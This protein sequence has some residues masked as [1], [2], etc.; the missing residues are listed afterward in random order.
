MPFAAPILFLA[1][2]GPASAQEVGWPDLSSPVED[3]AR[4]T[5]KD[6]ALVVGISEYAQLPDI[7]GASSLAGAWHA[8]FTQ[9]RE[10][11]TRRAILLRDGEATRAAV[12][13]AAAD[14]ALEVEGGGTLWIVFI[15]HGATLPSGTDALLL[16]SDTG[17]TPE[18]VVAGGVALGSLL[19]LATIATSSSARTVMLLDASFTGRD[20][21]GARL[22]EG[23]PEARPWIGR[24]V[25]DDV[26]LFLGAGD[27]GTARLL[28]GGEWPAFGYLSLGALRGWA[29]LDRDGEVSA[30]EVRTWT[31]T[32]L[33][34]L[35]LSADQVP[36]LR[37]RDLG[38]VL[39]RRA[40][41]GPDLAAPALEATGRAQEALRTA[42]LE[43]EARLRAEV[44]EAWAAVQALPDAER[45]GAARAFLSRYA[46]ARVTRGGLTRWV[47]LPQRKEAR[48]LLLAAEPPGRPAPLTVEQASYQ[49]LQEE[50][51]HLATRNAWKGVDAA[52]LRMEALQ[53]AG[54]VLTG[55]DLLAAA[56]ASRALG[57]VR[58]L[59]DR[60][61]RSLTI[62]PS[63]E[64]VEW[65]N[66]VE[67][68]YGAVSLRREIPDAAPVQ[69]VDPPF[70][71]EERNA[72]DFGNQALEAEAA[73]DGWLPTGLYRFG[74]E[75]LL[76][77][78]G[79]ACDCRLGPSGCEVRR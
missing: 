25:G 60:L 45:A 18:G 29:D 44:E 12:A 20:R 4:G 72:I 36:D 8:W 1:L 34:S 41:A 21:D 40:E 49:Q 77:T 76:V 17:A 10:I 58:T 69:P 28:P 24:V 42:L 79:S 74:G 27:T 38:R 62:Q 53:G 15:G 50:M 35:N 23:L 78:P 5:R 55:A 67:A 59:R 75:V 37:G 22:V 71:P 11:P 39:G 57:D 32:T 54:A 13:H 19:D 14:L 65:L 26:L 70:S 9:A 63:P 7:P 33:R 30:E 51:R 43:D 3:P 52:F 73:F 48:D 68:G 6:A 47:W 61:V 31:G 64:V 56:Q 46:D 2:A 66:A 16:G